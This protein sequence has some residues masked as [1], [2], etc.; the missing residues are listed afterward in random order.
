MENFLQAG[1]EQNVRNRISCQITGQVQEAQQ[2]M[3]MQITEKFPD[4][5]PN[6]FSS[7]NINY[8]AQISLFLRSNASEDFHYDATFQ[9]SFGL[10]YWL[11]EYRG[12][13]SRMFPQTRDP[14]VSRPG[15]AGSQHNVPALSKLA[16]FLL[17]SQN[18][19][20]G[21]FAGSLFCR[22]VELQ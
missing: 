5:L 10:F 6:N 13:V 8:P 21:M 3:V 14:S 19:M 9:F 17:A 7:I 20:S 11:K 1:L 22:L 18:T 16:F 12:M 4:F 15:L 2:N